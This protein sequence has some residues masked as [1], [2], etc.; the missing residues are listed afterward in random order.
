M[1]HAGAWWAFHARL[2]IA[3]AQIAMGG[4]GPHPV[5][6]T[7]G[8]TDSGLRL[9]AVRDGE[10][11]WADYDLDGDLDL[12][13]VGCS[14]E[15]LGFCGGALARVYRNDAGSFTDIQAG[16]TGVWY[17][18]AAWGDYDN[19]NDPDIFITGHTVSGPTGHLYRNN[20]DHTFTDIPAI[21]PSASLGSVDWGDYDQDGRV[22]LLL[23][24]CTAVGCPGLIMMLTVIWISC[25]QV[26]LASRRC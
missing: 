5:T 7:G 4:L 26:T 3:I 22:D 24:A 25:W 8:L 11:A 19:D 13:L 14:I 23:T 21:L 18:A 12:L 20:G 15:N 17:G 6:A 9:P 10:T 2:W 16:L 1:M